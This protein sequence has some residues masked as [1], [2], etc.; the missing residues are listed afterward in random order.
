MAE[1]G[2]LATLDVDDAIQQIGNGVLS[3][4]IASKWNVAPRTL[5][6][7]LERAKPAEYKQAV[8]DQAHAL[9][10]KAT[11]YC[12][13][14][15]NKDDAPIARVRLEG[16]KTWAAA[17]DPERWAPKGNTVNVQVNVASDAGLTCFASDLLDSLRTSPEASPTT[18]YSVEDKSSNDGA[19]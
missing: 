5:R 8:K 11:L 14:C 13:E 6:A 12:I 18:T 17:I 15:E 7:K 3:H 10:E 19:A 16:A 4:Q 9:V 2:A 1:R